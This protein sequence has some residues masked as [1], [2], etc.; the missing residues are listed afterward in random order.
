[1]K[2]MERKKKLI[3]EMFGRRKPN[4]GEDKKGKSIGSGA[5]V[6]KSENNVR[7]Q[8]AKIVY[9]PFETDASGK[10]SKN[11]SHKY[12][13]STFYPKGNPVHPS[14]NI[15]LRNKLNKS[16][17][18][19]QPPLITLNEIGQKIKNKSTITRNP[20][21]PTSGIEIRNSGYGERG[22]EIDHIV[23]LQV[24][25]QR[26]SPPHEYA[27]NFVKQKH[28]G[29]TLSRK[30]WAGIY[31]DPDNTQLLRSRENRDKGPKQLWQYTKEFGWG[32]NKLGGKQNLN[33]VRQASRYHD[34]LKKYGDTFDK[35]TMTREEAH[36][37]YQ[38]TGKEAT[39]PGS[40]DPE[41]SPPPMVTGQ[42][43]DAS[44]NVT[45]AGA[46]R[47]QGFNRQPMSN[48]EK[49]KDLK[50]KA[51][52]AIFEDSLRQGKDY[53]NASGRFAE[54]PIKKKVVK[55]N[56]TTKKDKKSII[57][58]KTDTK[59][60][61]YSKGGQWVQEGNDWVMTD[62]HPDYGKNKKAEKPKP[63]KSKLSQI[64]S[65]NLKEIRKKQ[66]NM[67]SKK[68]KKNEYEQEFMGEETF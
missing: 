14:Y 2:Y 54:G 16:Q 44:G 56:T 12:N 62:K 36:A 23:P 7:R 29:K 34:A 60:P 57:T 38:I 25:H 32:T 58:K 55:T 37:Y 20:I 51:E 47:D 63:K 42:E 48:K 9:Q 49:L 5:E 28:K 24:L 61:V 19:V 27:E 64:N 1:M 39:A 41:F 67:L 31:A 4:K 26:L 66:K 21:S 68:K 40:H 3:S 17:T 18:P 50:Y 10:V 59:K 43:Q 30:D 6:V 46:W 53:K 8:D 35:K 65:V 15:K 11:V 52:K 22:G 13:R 45:K 33:P